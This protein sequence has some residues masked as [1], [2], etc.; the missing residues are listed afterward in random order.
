MGYTSQYNNNIQESIHQMVAS[1]AAFIERASHSAVQ[2]CVED[3]AT[4]KQD[5]AEAQREVLYGT[6]T[7]DVI[8]KAPIAQGQFQ[9]KAVGNR[10]QLPAPKASGTN[11]NTPN[12]WILTS[13]D[14]S[15]IAV[16][17]EVLVACAKVGSSFWQ[18]LW[19]Q[20]TQSMYSALALAKPVADAVVAQYDAQA[21]SSDA[22]ASMNKNDGWM[23]IGFSIASFVIAGVD[24]YKGT[25][26][27]VPG[28]GTTQ[29]GAKGA[30]AAGE[31]GTDAEK[32]AAN[33]ESEVEEVNRAADS[34]VNG[35]TNAGGPKPAQA[36]D[37]AVGGKG[38]V[39]TK[40]P[41]PK[42]AASSGAGQ[43]STEARQAATEKAN[44]AGRPNEVARQQAADQQAVNGGR[45]PVTVAG[46]NAG[47]QNSTWQSIKG[48]LNR[49]SSLKDPVWKGFMK[50][51]Q[52]AAGMGV[53][54]D[55]IC[56]VAYDAPAR[57]DI[58]A[59]QR[60]VGSQEAFSKQGEMIAQFH[61]QAFNRAEDLRQGAQQQQIDT[62]MNVLKSAAD[63]ITQAVLAQ[64]V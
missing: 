18:N 50:G 54:A 5:R 55:G 53:M 19:S 2:E 31:A 25:P 59:A 22:E 24:V 11:S 30:G 49:M 56:G 37:S 7:K 15:I 41:T 61:N 12:D 63:T 46:Q 60:N 42:A 21:D 36:N 52:V 3:Q 13:N 58:A 9:G 8:G 27:L 40:A 20:A 1:D 17:N 6:S 45:A 35:G 28:A 14:I 4:Q 57:K 33:A 38:N 47:T 51:F 32:T 62:P 39:D 43:P 34:S 10:I 23:K 44:A 29:I 48:V 16:L 64:H 26:E